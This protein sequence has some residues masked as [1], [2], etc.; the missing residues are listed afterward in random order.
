M[1]TSLTYHLATSYDRNTLKSNTLDRANKPAVF[2]TYPGSYK[3]DL[4]APRPFPEKS[5][6][7]IH[8]SGKASKQSVDLST[9]SFIL[10]LTYA[11]TA[12]ARHAD[13]IF[14]YRS[15]ASAGALYPIEL[16]VGAYD[17]AGI[18]TGFY[19]F[20]IKHRQL[21]EIHHE[22]SRISSTNTGKQ[23]TGGAVIASFFITAVF[24][25]SSWKYR[26]RAYRYVLLDAG[27]L[28]HNL[29]LALAALGIPHTCRLDFHDNNMNAMLGL[30]ETFEACLCCVHIHSGSGKIF[31]P[32]KSL[33]FTDKL[34]Q[35]LDKTPT[36]DAGIPPLL[37]HEIHRSGKTTPP[38]TQNSPMAPLDIGI[39]PEKWIK[40]PHFTRSPNEIRYPQAVFFRRSKRNFIKRPIKSGVLFKLLELFQTSTEP[41]FLSPTDGVFPIVPAILV[42]SVYG[43]KPGLYLCDVKH[44]RLGL[45]T[46]GDFAST[47]AS[48]CLEQRWL[49]NASVHF[50]FLTNLS[51]IDASW[52][53]RGYR[54]AMIKAGELGQSLYVGATALGLGCCGIGAIFDS[55]A[56]TLLGLNPNSFLLYLVAVGPVK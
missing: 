18:N 19:H 37:I 40:T 27:H 35:P 2:K 49:R 33:L 25:R 21:A 7:D 51:W 15:T 24:F 9:L 29:F 34:F 46:S 10:D 42:N 38:F 50:L 13:G 53:A 11:L 31:H 54:Y 44:H 12:K 43:I 56:R 47:M 45:V 23:K 32:E 4:A 6:W 22:V 39:Q 3:I 30:D 48:I 55:E 5:L 20:D 26:Q 1:T 14:Y 8:A 28:L 17:V 41:S 16:Y 52:G 36:S